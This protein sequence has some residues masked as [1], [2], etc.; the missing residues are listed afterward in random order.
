M[1]VLHTITKPSFYDEDAY[2]DI[3]N[4]LP[5]TI[6]IGIFDW[7]LVLM[8]LQEASFKQRFGEC[9]YNELTIRIQR[10]MPHPTKFLD[11][12][13]HE[14]CHAIISSYNIEIKPADAQQDICE[15]QLVSQFALALAQVFLDNPALGRIVDMV[16][17]LRK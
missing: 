10:D 13:L 9:D 17:M 16:R 14:I 2:K 4:S 3:L 5:Q 1:T 6:R 11:T 7:R 15:E 12:L 8:D